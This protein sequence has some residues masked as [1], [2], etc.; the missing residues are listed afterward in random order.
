MTIA[1][2]TGILSFI[3]TLSLGVNLPAAELKPPTAD[4]IAR[5]ESAAPSKATTAPKRPRKLLILTQCEGF[6]HSSVPYAAK[7]LAIMGRKTG[8]FDATVVEDLAILER[9]EFDTFDAIAMDNTTLRLPLLPLDVRGMD[10]AQKV[11]ADARDNRARQRFL[12]FIRNGKGLVGIHAATDC[13]SDWPEYGELIGGYFDG[14]PWSENVRV[15]LDDPG[16]PLVAAFNGQPFD[17]TDEIYQFR[18]PYSREKLRVLLSLDTG[19][20]NM[21]KQGI[22]RQDKDFAVAWIREYGKGRVF[23]FSLGHRHEILWN[24]PILR[25]YLDG[26]QYALG[27]LAADAKPSAN[28][29]REELDRSRD[30]GM[31]AGL[32]NA[33]R[34]LASY[35][36]D[37][38]PGLPD[39]L[40]RLVGDT[41]APDATVERAYLADGLATV[42]ADSRATPDARALACRHLALIGTERVVPILAPLLTDDA[43]ADWARHALTGIRGAAADRALIA[44]L[45]RA[46]GPNRIGIVGLLGARRVADATAALSS[47]LLRDD[48][49][50]A[51]IAAA[52]ALGHIG[53]SATEDPLTEARAGN[54][55]PAANAAIDRALLDIAEAARSSGDRA[56][57]TKIYER[58]AGDGSVAPHVRAAAFYGATML[59]GESGATDAV[60][61]LK[62]DDVERA[63]AAARLITDL[64]GQAI[65]MAIAGALPALKPAS[66]ELAL[67]ALAKRGER[68][69]LP[70]VMSLLA[71]QDGGVRLAA[72]RAVGRLGDASTV[73]RVIAVAAD[74]A[75]DRAERDA[76]RETLASMNGPGVDEA[77]IAR[78]TAANGSAKSEYAKALGTRRARAAFPAL[79]AAA[80]DSDAA[81]AR[82]A[83][84]ALGQLAQPADIGALVALLVETT[85]MAAIDQIQAVLVATAQQADSSQTKTA[86]ILA[87]LAGQPSD[88]ARCGLLA[89]LGRIGDPAGQPALVSVLGH[90]NAAIRRAAIK[91]L[92]ESWP[93]A[94]PVLALR[95]ASRSDAD[96]GNR[97]LALRGYARMLA[98]PS[99]RPMK[100][101][102]ALYREALDLA[103]GKQ[104]KCALIA[105]LGKLAHPDALEFVKP[106]FN[107]PDA[108][109]EAFIAA[110]AIT[111]GLAGNGMVLTASLG[112]GSERNAIDGSAKT[113]WT[114]GRHMAGGEWFMI[115]LGYET[116]LRELFLDAGPVGADQPRGYEVYISLDGKTWG[117][118][119]VTGGDPVE[120]AF[121]I[122]L[123]STYGRFIKI[124]QTGEAK[125][126]WSINELRVNGLPEHRTSAPL[127]RTG[128][129]LSASRSGGS[130]P[131]SNAIGGDKEKRWGTGGA[132]RPDDW[133]MVDLG[134]EHAIHAV[135][136]DA[137]KSGNDY[138][139]EYRIETS[140]DGQNWV[141]PI[142]AGKGTKALTTA[143]CLPTRARY[144]KIRQTGSHDINWWSI[145]DLQILGE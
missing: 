78:M 69:A 94:D 17:V 11:E 103:K 19:A 98:M 27:D 15:K 91:A 136:M 109:T 125:L 53:G 52:E 107:D 43:M 16:H 6:P 83:R 58:V 85:D 57:A 62:G 63:R 75:R 114:T 132:M 141:G 108:H 40:E 60:K 96:E 111:D 68:S 73:E 100:E 135:V 9:T 46:S 129:T 130:S 51:A 66:Q 21:S 105:G 139:R 117:D 55:S 101:T 72:L 3:L 26:I 143:R 86:A 38:G 37:Q 102:L 104:E 106:Y 95:D 116:E 79:I 5:M 2:R 10:A 77:L 31:A 121:T 33:L 133:F 74:E 59:K 23:Y 24:A 7:A 29:S 25:C 42:V 28:L 4:E 70:A 49:T 30:T 67:D 20:I 127:D 47:L 64:P 124:V 87:A 84:K 13:L 123:P 110:L 88:N 48:D 36:L 41:L 144:V 50:A 44:A 97:I 131:P 22:K 14:H 113:R 120:K 80:R 34:D 39:Q 112:Q 45:P 145:H 138:P 137:A 115:D 82:E 18:A 142:G 93:D 1:T 89:A 65:V 122:A 119:V 56:L 140:L 54:R 35:T 32:R 134:A 61:V 81:L 92:A 118:P 76:A 128:W 71:S 126:F 8:A 99:Q 12:D 90:A